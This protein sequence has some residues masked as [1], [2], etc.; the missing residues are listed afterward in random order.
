MMTGMGH[1]TLL[2]TAPHGGDQ[3]RSWADAVK[4]SDS[5]DNTATGQ[6]LLLPCVYFQLHARLLKCPPA[7]Q[8]E[9]TGDLA[10]DFEV[11][12][13][14]MGNLNP[15]SAAP[16]P[17]R[18][19][20]AEA[21]ADRAL[22]YPASPF[23]EAAW[24]G[25]AGADPA[26]GSGTVGTHARSRCAEAEEEGAGARERGG[27]H[28]GLGSCRA[29]MG[30]ACWDAPGGSEP[31]CIPVPARVGVMCG[32]LVGVYDLAAGTIAVRFG[33]DGRVRKSVY[34]LKSSFFLPANSALWET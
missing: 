15:S 4:S 28:V 6:L 1:T 13:A 25:C 22:P 8:L 34:Q 16:M 5:T 3:R 32:G 31:G 21:G 7:A 29:M 23:A 18:L 17:R 30:V 2:C 10:E 27:F 11:P 9:R 14:R 12:R 20:A 19:A 33:E 26:K 24:R